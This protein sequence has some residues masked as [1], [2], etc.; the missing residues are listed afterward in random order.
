VT[1]RGR[2][3]TLEGVDGA[4]KSTHLAWLAE[5]I[6]ALGHEVVVTREPGGT[7]LGEALRGLLLNQQMHPETEA[8]LMFGARREHVA[9]IIEPALARGDWVLCDRFSDASFA[10]Q[11]A[12][13]GVA[14]PKLEILER[15]VHEHISPDLTLLFD[16]SGET[17]KE[18]LS[19]VRDPDKFES[20]DARFFNKVREG[21]R[22]RMTADPKRFVLIDGRH[23]IEQIRAELSLILAAF[24]S[25]K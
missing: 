23:S 13:R 5:T 21:Y 11:G 20:E 22:A 25:T 7:N 18:R 24:D 3:I 2:M 4:G 17:A 10:Y 12:A 15:W 1:L 9:A 6:K 8:L 16:L 19:G 14:L